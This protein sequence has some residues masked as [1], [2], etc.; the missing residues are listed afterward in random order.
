MNTKI[1]VRYF[2]SLRDYSLK[3]EESI[4]TEAKTAHDLFLELSERYH[5][6]LK[7][8][9][10][11]VSINDEYKPMTSPICTGDAVVFIPP[12]AGG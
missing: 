4:A 10:V 11:R 9:Q 3:R 8:D 12:V 5:F 6:P 7:S 2:A 1:N